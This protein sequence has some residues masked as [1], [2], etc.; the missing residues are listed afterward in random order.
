MA[1]SIRLMERPESVAVSASGTWM[2]E[3]SASGTTTVR[4]LPSL[5]EVSRSNGKHAVPLAGSEE[6]LFITQ[7]GKAMAQRWTGGPSRLLFRAGNLA[8]KFAHDVKPSGDGR[9]MLFNEP[10]VIGSRD[11][12]LDLTNKST[13]TLERPWKGALRRDD[14]HWIRLSPALLSATGMAL[15]GCFLPLP[16]VR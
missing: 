14:W 12:V 16:G 1:Q 15:P 7:G 9:W 13:L 10:A 2:V 11:V 5:R 3:S 8:G 4:E 6:F